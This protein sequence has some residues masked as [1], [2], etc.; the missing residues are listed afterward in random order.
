MG[1]KENVLFHQLVDMYLIWYIRRA[2]RGIGEE[3]SL[4]GKGLKDEV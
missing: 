1:Y 3:N 4:S 2:V